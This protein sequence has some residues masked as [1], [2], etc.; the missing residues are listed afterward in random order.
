MSANEFASKNSDLWVEMEL[1]L[2]VLAV[3][4]GQII[5]RSVQQRQMITGFIVSRRH[6]QT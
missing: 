5:A 4:Y 3:R 6:N 1:V 2:L